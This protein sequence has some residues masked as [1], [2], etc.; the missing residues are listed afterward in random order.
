L[1]EG[2]EVGLVEQADLLEQLSLLG[3]GVELLLLLLLLRLLLVGG[4]GRPVEH[5]EA[6][7]LHLVGREE[8]L[9]GLARD[10]VPHLLELSGKHICR[11]PPPVCHRRSD[12]RNAALGR[13]CSWAGRGAVISRG[14]SGRH[15]TLVDD[16][17]QEC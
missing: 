16:S 6:Q 11:G 13:R 10:I 7:G 15:L 1:H 14:R 17:R 9:A 3:L 5:D 12:G 2:Q 4:F 8:Q